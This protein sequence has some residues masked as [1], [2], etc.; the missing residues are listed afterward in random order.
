MPLRSFHAT[1]RRVNKVPRTAHAQNGPAL[2]HTAR[3]LPINM[4]RHTRTHKHGHTNSGLHV[5]AWRTKLA[6]WCRCL[7]H[8]KQQHQQQRLQLTIKLTCQLI[9]IINFGVHT[10]S[11]RARAYANKHAHALGQRECKREGERYRQVE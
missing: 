9:F 3:P 10:F 7:Q 11:S 1:A 8:Q 4:S 6:G 5:R 2:V